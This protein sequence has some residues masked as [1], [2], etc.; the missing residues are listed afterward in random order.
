MF[1]LFLFGTAVVAVAV[2]AVAVA[3][4]IIKHPFLFVLPFFVLRTLGTR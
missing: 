2:V 3:V 4:C 1:F